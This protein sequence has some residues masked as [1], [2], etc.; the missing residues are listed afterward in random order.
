M[1]IEETTIF[2]HFSDPT[3]SIF[4]WAATQTVISQDYT[5][6]KTFKSLVEESKM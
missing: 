5:N 4:L 1:K 6:V 3:S 2:S